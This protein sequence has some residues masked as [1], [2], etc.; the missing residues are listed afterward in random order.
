MNSDPRKENRVAAVRR[1]NRFYTREIGVLKDGYLGTPYSLT[2]GRVL[3]EL[4]HRKNP[5]D[6]ATA[7]AV[8]AALDLDPGYL[9]RIVRSFRKSRLIR[10]DR[11][12]SDGRETLLSLTPRGRQAIAQLNIRSN[13]EV[14]A[15]LRPIPESEKSRLVTAMHTIEHLLAPE[16]AAQ[17]EPYI[18]RSPQLGD[19]GWIAHRQGLLYAQEYNWDEHYE[20]LVAKIVGQFVENFDPRRERCWMA[21]RHNEIVGSV[22]LVKNTPSIAKL[23]LLYVEPSARGLGIG[24]RLVSECIRFARQAG[25]KKLTLWTQSNL[26]AA[27]R[28]YKSQ[29]FRVTAKKRHHSF[30]HNLVAETWD[31]KL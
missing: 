15:R 24:Q 14:A 4:A 12:P 6:K 21:E 1:F 26:Y 2:E 10:T 7:S 28:I 23:R 29:G 9:S 17:K 3:Y 25:Y 18:L 19:M 11:S 13:K 8:C 30:G 20:A 31:R 27:R 22:L 5:T 16:S